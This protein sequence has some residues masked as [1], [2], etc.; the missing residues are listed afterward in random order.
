MKNQENE[1][2]LFKKVLSKPKIKMKK[3]YFITGNESK[4]KEA[5]AILK[6]KNINLT[7]IN[8]KLKETQTLSQEQVVR[9]KARQAFEVLQQPVIV[10]DTGIYF[11]AY[12]NFPGTYT[13][14]LFEGIGFEG[15]LR[16][17]KTKNKKAY[18]KTLLCYKDS[19]TEKVSSGVWKGKITE[20]ISKHFNPDWQYNSIFIPEGFKK[21]LSEI[22]LEERAK[23][24]HRKKAF[25]KL[26]K[27]LNGNKDETNKN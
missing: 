6:S 2:K 13:R 3:I 17:L 10:D 12:E 15:L 26:N 9:E 21:H 11:S 16:L 27:Y 8:L 19:K 1:T 23:N 5:E 24:S 20:N 22:P 25:D 4:F 7:Q 14:L 18:F